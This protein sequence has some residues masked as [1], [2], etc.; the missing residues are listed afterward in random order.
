MGVFSVE[1][2]DICSILG[3]DAT[4]VDELGVRACI[5][6]GG[7]VRGADEELRDGAGVTKEGLFHVV[8]EEAGIAW[9]RMGAHSHPLSLLEES[10]HMGVGL[11]L[12]RGFNSEDLTE[13]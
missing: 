9:T 3:A 5:L 1:L 2:E 11:L 10:E 13:A 6:A 7:W 4:E 8:C 12:V